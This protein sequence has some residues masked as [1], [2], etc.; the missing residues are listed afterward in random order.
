MPLSIDSV[1]AAV[2]EFQRAYIYKIFIE[3]V[4]AAVLA[5]NK[6]ALSFSK[7]VDLYN[8]TA[9]FSDR[10]TNNTTIKWGGE[11]IDIPTG[12]ASTRNFDFSFYDD[13]KMKVYDFFCSCKDLTGNEDNQAQVISTLSKFNMGIAKVSVDKETIT[14]YRHLIGCRVYGVKP[15]NTSKSSEE[16]SKIT[17]SIRWDKNL[18]DK[19]KRGLKV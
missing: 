1:A 11:F 13:E 17:V 16:V 15:E 10:M 2:G 8:D 7:E 19:L 4:P 18:E 12:D 9:V 14:A 5:S 3:S 6:D